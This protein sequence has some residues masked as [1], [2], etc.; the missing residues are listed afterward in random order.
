MKSPEELFYTKE[1]GLKR[2]EEF[3]REF[4]HIKHPCDKEGFAGVDERA[5]DKTSSRGT[6]EGGARERE[7]GTRR[8]PFLETP[9]ARQSEGDVLADSGVPRT[10]AKLTWH[11]CQSMRHP[12]ALISCGDDLIF[13]FA[14]TLCLRSFPHGHPCGSEA[15]R[16]LHQLHVAEILRVLLTCSG[17]ATVAKLSRGACSSSSE[18]GGVP[19]LLLEKSA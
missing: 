5:E 18:L 6:Q 2:R 4:I 13:S 19:R 11:S 9:G 16:S 3:E 15:N 10:K 17:R 12:S 14:L 8:S 1:K 7:D